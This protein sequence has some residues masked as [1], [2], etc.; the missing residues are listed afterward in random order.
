MN[1]DN[2][3]EFT[4][5][6]HVFPD[7][8]CSFRLRH[9]PGTMFPLTN[10]LHIFVSRDATDT[11]TENKCVRA[12]FGQPWYGDIVVV[13]YGKTREEVCHVVNHEIDTLNVYVGMYV[14]VPPFLIRVSVLTPF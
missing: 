11:Q 2:S 3:P 12:L 8:A 14:A 9:V 5:L 10:D 4:I 1:V 7:G 6:D 13:K